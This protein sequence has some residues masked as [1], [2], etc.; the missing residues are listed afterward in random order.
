MRIVHIS[1]GLWKK[2]GGPAESVPLLLSELSKHQDVSI[3]LVTLTGELSDNVTGLFNSNVDVHILNYRYYPWVSYLFALP[4]IIRDAD[5]VHIQGIWLPELWI[6]NI[7]SHYY[8]KKVIISPRGFLHP[9]RLRVSKQKKKIAGF[10][11][12]KNF[13]NKARAIHVTS[14]QEKENVLRYGIGAECFN[15]RNGVNLVSRQIDTSQKFANKT[16]LYFGRLNPIKGIKELMQG[17]DD[18]SNSD[19]WRLLICGPDENNFKTELLHFAKSLKSADNIVFKP[20]VYGEDKQKIFD[21]STVMALVSHGEN[22]G[23]SV[24]ESLMNKTPVLVSPHMP[25]DDVVNKSCGWL[26]E[27]NA[28]SI[29][30]AFTKV[31]SL[32]LDT[33]TMYCQN[34]QEWMK[35]GFTWKQIGKEFKK[36]YERLLR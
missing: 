17:F 30:R 12:D 33:Y 29:T 34:G 5:I 8:R 32:D 24:A 14:S 19:S 18:W 2:S 25:W 21:S 10:L 1:S 11:L 9:N 27:V 20:P 31:N 22:F 26:A 7:V 23:I 13:L 16:I 15:I 4:A 35:N 3:A 28:K 36:E 6:A